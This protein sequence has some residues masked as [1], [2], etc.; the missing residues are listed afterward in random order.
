VG[1]D[2]R[3]VIVRRMVLIEHLL[4][5]RIGVGLAFVS[6]HLLK[7]SFELVDKER[8][9]INAPSVQCN[10]NGWQRRCRIG[11]TT[12][13]A[14]ETEANDSWPSILTRQRPFQVNLNILDHRASALEK[15][16]RKRPNPL[17]I[18]LYVPC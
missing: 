18:F 12:A 6:P 15:I 8:V 14:H 5:D 16:Q 7:Q 4:E 11:S 9:R 13:R 10:N 1:E 17:G 3:V 2:S